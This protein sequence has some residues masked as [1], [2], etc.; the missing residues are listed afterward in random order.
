MP[1]KIDTIAPTYIGKDAISLN[2]NEDSEPLQAHKVLQI[3]I[4]YTNCGEE[5]VS[6]PV[7]L[8]IQPGFGGGGTANGYTNK[9]YRRTAPSRILY[10][11]PQGG[12][13]LILLREIH[14]NRYQGRLLIE[15]AGDKYA[16]PIVRERS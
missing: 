3:D 4:D 6:V 1:S 7:E 16:E 9:I 14:H 10:R 5:G 2:I 15:V 11:P 8:I 13:Y 12:E